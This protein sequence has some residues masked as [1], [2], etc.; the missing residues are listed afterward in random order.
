MLLIQYQINFRIM[1]FI[2]CECLKHSR[3]Q[4]YNDMNVPHLSIKCKTHVTGFRNQEQKHNKS[5]TGNNQGWEHEA[6]GP[7]L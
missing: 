7:V 3:L 5:N 1:D 2:M 4:Q 6:Q